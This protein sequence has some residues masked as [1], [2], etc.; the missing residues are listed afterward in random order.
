[1]CR[2]ANVLEKI[3]SH[4][5][6]NPKTRPQYLEPGTL[7]MRILHAELWI[8]SFTCH[9]SFEHHSVT[10][11]SREQTKPWFGL[12]WVCPDILPFCWASQTHLCLV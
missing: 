4:D 12:D 8:S 5:I 3:Q 10:T 9:I 1:M 2:L 6:I 11:S 7:S